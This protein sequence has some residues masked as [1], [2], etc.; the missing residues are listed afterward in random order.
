MATQLFSSDAGLPP[1]S[2]IYR[3]IST[4]A[5]TDPLTYSKIDQL[6]IIASDDSLR[7]LNPDLTAVDVRKNANN[8][9]TCLE[10]ANDAS[11]NVVTTAGRDG[12]IRYWDKRTREKVMEIQSRMSGQ[13]MSCIITTDNRAA[14]KLISSLVCSAE[15]NFVACGTENPD[16]GAHESPVYVW[17]EER[18]SAVACAI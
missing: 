7:F 12:L 5:R 9:I 11:S 4:A 18:P 16:D 1:N 13:Y 2:Y 15:V 3:I 17:Y 8:S 6:A 10:R 14:S